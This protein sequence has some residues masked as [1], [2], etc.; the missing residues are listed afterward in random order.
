MHDDETRRLL[1]EPTGRIDVPQ[2]PVDNGT[3]DRVPVDP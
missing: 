2:R 1:V 3:R